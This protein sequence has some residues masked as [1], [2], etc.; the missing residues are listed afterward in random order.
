MEST[1]ALENPRAENSAAAAARIK[2]LVRLASRPG[3]PLADFLT[4]D[5]FGNLFYLLNI[6]QS[7]DEPSYLSSEKLRCHRFERTRRRLRRLGH[8]RGANIQF[9]DRNSALALQVRFA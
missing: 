2:A 5:I 8:R 9:S 7:P 6:R 3:R 4:V 1:K